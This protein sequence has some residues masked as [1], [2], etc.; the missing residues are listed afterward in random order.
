[1]NSVTYEVHNVDVM[2]VEGDPAFDLKAMYY[3]FHEWVV[4]V[5]FDEDDNG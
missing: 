4:R 2:F 3:H 5:I 1:M